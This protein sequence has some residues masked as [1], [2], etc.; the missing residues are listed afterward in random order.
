MLNMKKYKIVLIILLP[1]SIFL[2]AMLYT[3]LPI[4]LGSGYT[5]DYNPV[6]TDSYIIFAPRYGSNINGDVVDYVYNNTYIV[7][8]EKSIDTFE[9]LYSKYWYGVTIEK[10]MF[11]TFSFRQIWGNR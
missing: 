1:V 5:Y 7:A 9:Q 11:D 4:D 10:Q 8:E 3:T 6:W 2:F